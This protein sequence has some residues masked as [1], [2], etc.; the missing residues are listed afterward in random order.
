M[1]TLFAVCLVALLVGVGV[2][3]LIETDPGYVLVSYGTVTLE[4]SLW[5]GL[6]VLAVALFIVYLIVR[7]VYRLL[8]GRR[9]LVSWLG[10]RRSSQAVKSTTR[11]IVSYI[12]GNWLR[13]RR[14]LLRGV[15]NND[16]PLVN[17][18]LAARASAQL[19]EPEQVAEFLQAASDAEPSA[20]GAIDILRAQNKVRAGD[21]AQA[22]SILAQS[23][24]NVAR[25]PRVL[26]L[27]QQ[28]YEGQGEWDQLLGLLPDLRKNKLLSDEESEQLERDIALRRL[29]AATAAADLDSVWQGLPSRV[30]QDSAVLRRYV[31]RLLELGEHAVAEKVIQRALKRQWD[32]ELVGQYAMLDNDN[33]AARLSHAERWLSDHPEDAQLLL[34]LGRLCLRDNLWGKARDYFESSYRIEPGAQVCAELGRLLIGLGEPKVAS[35]YYR[36]GLSK[37]EAVLPD[38]PMPDKVVA[39]HHTLERSEA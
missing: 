17:Y 24:H 14:H 16:A 34:C 8:G 18:L 19:Q 36:E 35:A 10:N 7:L 30:K 25:H 1:R 4:T 6:V 28:A 33:A 3:A 12:E 38:L 31:S 23:Q 15:K 9:T 20:A 37:T 27:L 26:H 5:V 32:T 39:N 22:Q 2:V 29:R 11:G 21:F 13:A